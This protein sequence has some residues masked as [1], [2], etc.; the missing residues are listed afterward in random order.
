MQETLDKVQKWLKSPLQISRYTDLE[1]INH[2]IENWQETYNKIKADDW[3]KINSTLDWQA[4][5]QR[6]RDECQTRFNIEPLDKLLGSKLGYKLV[7]ANN[8]TVTI[9]NADNFASSTLIP[10]EDRSGF[11][12]FNSDPVLAHQACEA[13]HCVTWTNGKIYKCHQVSHFEEFNRQFN[14]DFVSEQDQKLFM[15]YKPATID[16]S[17]AQLQDFFDNLVYPIPQC[18]FCPE[19]V[20]FNKFAATTQKLNFIKRKKIDYFQ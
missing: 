18:K 5:P 17:H 15:D 1:D 4:L 2:H 19:N 16:M 9:E 8:I 13:K 3:P 7:D 14:I 11:S 12:L 20:S 6:I 10:K